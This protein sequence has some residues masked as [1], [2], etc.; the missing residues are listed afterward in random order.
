MSSQDFKF[1]ITV[2]GNFAF[3]KIL[4]PLSIHM[5]KIDEK[6]KISNF[7]FSNNFMKNA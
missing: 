2:N 3:L 5:A 1:I 7:L 6:V 4:T